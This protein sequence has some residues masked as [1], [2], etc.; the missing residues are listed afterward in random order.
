MKEDKKLV[1]ILVRGSNDIG[2]AVAHRLFSAGY[3]TVIHEIPQPA[4]TRR[5]MAFTDAI[6]DGSASLE[7]V[8][9]LRIDDLFLMEA[10]LSS[11]QSVLVVVADFASLIKTLQPAILVD[12][13][14]RKRQQPEKQR[15]LAPLTIGLGPNFIAGENIDLAVETSWGDALGQVIYQGATLPLSGEPRPLAGHA[16][17]RYVY[18]PVGGV[19]TT[20]LQ[21]G[22]TVRAGQVVAWVNAT[23]L[24]APLSGRLRGLTHTGVPVNQGTKVIEVDPRGELTEIASVAGIA[25]RPRR[26]A[27]GVL[28]AIQS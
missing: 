18:A 13:R 23:P 21:V 27:E 17:D 19:F 20:E 12:A 15:G 26:I 2:S 9:A 25:E 28:Q 6:F 22:D 8:Q 16:R 5:K 14:M 11:P 7:G 3:P 24:H 1:R 10:A 4:V